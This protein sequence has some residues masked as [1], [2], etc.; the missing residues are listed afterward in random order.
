[1][2]YSECLDFLFSQLP[3]YQKSGTSA[4]K[5]DLQ[6]IERLCEALGNPQRTLKCIHVAG[7]NGKGSS[8]HALASILQ[9][10][11]YR[12]ALYTS[13]HLKDYRERIKIDGEPIAK[14]KVVQFIESHQQVINALKPSFFELTVALALDYFAEQH[15]DIAVIE[16]GLGG[17]LDSTNIIDP[18]V[19]LI[20]NIGFDHQMFLGD[21][22]PEIAAEKAGIIKNKVP[23][24]IGEKDLQ[25]AQIF[26]EKA[27]QCQAPIYYA[28]DHY[29]IRV[30]QSI[31]QLIMEVHGATSLEYEDLKMDLN[32]PYQSQN[33]PGILRVIDLLNDLE[34]SISSAHVERGLRKVVANTGIKGRWQ[35]IAANPMVICDTGHNTAA[36]EYLIAHLLNI[37]QGDLHMVLGFVNDKDING[38]LELLPK[39]AH[40]YFCSANVPRSLSGAELQELAY[41]YGLMGRVIEDV[42]EALDEAKAQAS[43]QDLIFVGG[44]TFVVAEVKGI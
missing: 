26:S 25:T 31:P 4:I 43:D 13:P 35:Q 8:C 14:E 7:T 9:E 36:M 22:L 20:T 38:M 30:V 18:L 10:A 21:T 17:K 44:S 41:T 2:T 37:C 24:V 29:K 23:V 6:N 1:M 19:C 33:V 3:L 5:Y 16:V 40:Y 12:T 34:F 28:T 15:V 27:R 42:N 39:K 11:G 32:G